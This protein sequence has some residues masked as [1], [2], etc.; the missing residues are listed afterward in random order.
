MNRKALTWF[1]RGVLTLLLTIFGFGCGPSLLWFLNRGD[2]YKDPEPGCKFTPAEG[3]KTVTVAVIVT[4]PNH[5]TTHPSMM[6]VDRDLEAKIGSQLTLLSKIPKDSA[7]TVVDTGK[8]DQL[9]QSNP[10]LWNTASMADI[11]K[12]LGADYVLD[13]TLASLSF[14]D[15]QTGKEICRG[16]SSVSV[17]VYDAVGTGKPL[18]QYGH[19]SNAPL[20]DTSSLPVHL[21][22][23]TYLDRLATEIALK[24]VKHK[25]DRER[26]LSK[27]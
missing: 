23:N 20:R 22:R 11:A 7:I 19:Q 15:Q 1:R 14:F 9:R 21:Y 18:T 3:K 24:H 8:V 17:S 12:K 10:E 13:V 16:N 26:D 5:I 4:A 27:Q 6:G 2:E 25:A